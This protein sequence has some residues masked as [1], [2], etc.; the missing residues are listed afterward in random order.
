MPTT[1]NSESLCE[2]LALVHDPTFVKFEREQEIP[3][4]FGAA[5]R[6]FTETWHSAL[7]GWLLDPQG[8]HDLGTFPLERLCLLL[9][10]TDVLDADKR[11]LDLA[12][13][14]LRWD[15]ST[16]IVNPNERVTEEVSVG[17]VGRFDVFVKDIQPDGTGDSSAQWEKVSLLIEMKIDAKIDK[18]QCSRYIGYVEKEKKRKVLTVPIFVAPGYQLPQNVTIVD[19]LG[20]DLWIVFN[21]QY[22]V[23]G[24]LEPCLKHDKLS[25]FGRFTMQQYVAA[26]KRMHNERG[27]IL[28]TLQEKDMVRELYG[29]HK[30]AIAA[31][32]QILSQ[33]EFDSGMEP[34]ADGIFAKETIHIKIDGQNIEKPSVSK[35]YLAV[36]ELL[37]TAGKLN[38]LQLPILNGPKQYL[39]ATE[40]R[41][42]SGKDFIRDIEYNGYF[43]EANKSRESAVRDIKKLATACGVSFSQES[44]TAT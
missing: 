15:L 24:L 43:M 34:L 39:I 9:K 2:V 42:P 38:K 18:A 37:D 40:P 10:S 6:T 35:L 21:L 16:A 14:L 29:K 32:Y 22:L 30:N 17:D 25:D 3:S 26:W 31:M 44:P 8:S 27:E 23:V 7:L 12:E 5:G 33:P 20:S 4:I 41:H 19:L 1:T 13:L 28:M 11:G 36:L